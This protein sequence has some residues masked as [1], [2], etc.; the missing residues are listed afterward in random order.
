MQ[1]YEEL[2]FSFPFPV[3]EVYNL[4]HSRGKKLK[5]LSLRISRHPM[6]ILKTSTTRTTKTQGF[7]NYLSVNLQ[8]SS[9]T[10]C[11]FAA[12][13]TCAAIAWGQQCCFLLPSAAVVLGR[14]EGLELLQVASPK[15]CLQPRIGMEQF[16]AGSGDPSLQKLW[17]CQGF[18][19]CGI[20]VL[21]SCWQWTKLP[22]LLLCALKLLSCGTLISPADPL[23]C[24]GSL[25]ETSL[26]IASCSWLHRTP[27]PSCLCFG[28]CASNRS[29]RAENV[30]GS[31]LQPAKH[32]PAL[33][34]CHFQHLAGSGP[35]LWTDKS[36]SSFPVWHLTSLGKRLM[37]WL[38]FNRF[39]EARQEHASTDRI[40]NAFSREASPAC[41]VSVQQVCV[42]AWRAL[43]ELLAQDGKQGGKLP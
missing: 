8:A 39:Y 5:I 37:N 43:R 26:R 3:L 23:L 33:C 27:T 15:H 18:I 1:P 11:F 42:Q 10:H 32:L 28:S 20:E 29:R 9:E 2:F 41:F 36:L 6:K 4:Q 25:A 22:L 17:H 7:D 24:I 40:L 30:Q 38:A 31:I 21:A 34:G 14:G 19:C 16:K 12:W 35:F 13:L